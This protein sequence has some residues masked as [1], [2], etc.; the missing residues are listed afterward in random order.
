MPLNIGEVNTLI[1]KR[2]TNISYSLVEDLSSNNEI[3]LH[4]NQASRRLNIG[5]KIDVFLYFD[6][7]HRL[8]ATMEHPLI[9]TKQFGF[10]K[11]VDVKKEMGCFVNIGI[12]KDIL[13]SKDYLPTYFDSWPK[14]DE[15]IPCILKLK[16]DALIAKIIS[17]DD[18]KKGEQKLNIGDKVDAV[19]SH[20]TSSGL[21]AF[22]TSFDVIYIH[23][24]LMRKKHHIGEMLNV[25]IININE[26]KEYNGSLI[27]QKEKMRLIDSELILRY[28]N[29]FGGTLKLGNLST[30]EEIAKIF[31]LSKSAFK[32]AVGALYKERLIT[33]E[34]Y[35]IT[36]IKSE[37]KDST[38]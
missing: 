37:E 8:C 35:K 22:T 5:E 29:N 21:I 20:F 13:L 24:S 28:L 34:D 4:F 27:E 32:R 23:K 2:E 19:V 18:L 12:V 25:E 15:E 26:H 1:V 33:I 31:P 9:T 17:K 7:K 36:L 11:V 10:V 14:K 6:N 16:K 3:F 30:P 38:L